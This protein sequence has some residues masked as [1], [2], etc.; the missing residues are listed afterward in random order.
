ML[1]SGRYSMDHE[2]IAATDDSIVSVFVIKTPL[3]PLP[4]SWMKDLQGRSRPSSAVV[5]AVW[6][7]ET[8]VS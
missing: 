2:R 4:L 1:S 8:T 6:I 5:R 3:R 7:S